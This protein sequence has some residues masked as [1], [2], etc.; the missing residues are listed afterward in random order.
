MVLFKACPRC[1]GDVHMSSDVYGDFKEC[2]QC[3]L[4][5]DIETDRYKSTLVKAESKRRKKVA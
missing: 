3:G 1:H 5:I 4:I 2:L